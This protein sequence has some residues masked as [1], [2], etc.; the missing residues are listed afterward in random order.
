MKKTSLAS[1]GGVIAAVLASL[2]CIGPV[3]VLFLGVGSIA[4]FSV[5]EAYRPY[6]IGFTVVLIGL[7]FYLT[8]RKREIKCE[9]GKCTVERGSAWARTGIWGATI[10]AVVAIGFPYLGLAP[11]TTVNETVDSSAMVT[12][13]ID[14][15]DCKP[16]A[17]G[18][19]G[20]LASIDGVRKARVDF[21][22]GKATLEYNAHRVKP[23]A[24]VDRVHENGFTATIEKEE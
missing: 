18:L 24:F 11:H 14:G 10:V 9:D 17:L 19:E 1:V 20:S 23:A 8:Y 12:L 5:F 2:C 15:M 16:C 7:A 3:V 6:L 22:R 21:E 4:A 13:N